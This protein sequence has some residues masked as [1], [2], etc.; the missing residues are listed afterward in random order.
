M[1]EIIRNHKILRVIINI[2]WHVLK[3]IIF[4]TPHEKNY[5]SLHNDS[6]VLPTDSIKH[7]QRSLLGSHCLQQLVRYHQGCQRDSFRQGEER[8]ILHWCLLQH[9]NWDCYL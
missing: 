1:I 5:H 8:S 2:D 9:L 7:Q 6:S 4:L 3:K